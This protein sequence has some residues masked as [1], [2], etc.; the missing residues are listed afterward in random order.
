MVPADSWDDEDTQI[1]NKQCLPKPGVL[2][3]AW[4]HKYISL[5]NP[6]QRF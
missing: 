5:F 1:W 4:V 3:K 2:Q 6:Q